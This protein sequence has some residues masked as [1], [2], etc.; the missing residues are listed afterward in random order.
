MPRRARQ[1]LE[2]LADGNASG[3]GYRQLIAEALVQAH[4][5]GD[6]A[7]LHDELAPSSRPSYF[8][9]FVDHARTHGLQY[10]AEADYT[11][12]HTSV[13][14][15]AVALMLAE[16]DGDI[17]AKE[18]YLD[19]LKFRTFRQ[20]LLCRADA[21]LDRSLPPDMAQRFCRGPDAALARR[22]P[23]SCAC[24]PARAS[25]R[26]VSPRSSTASSTSSAASRYSRRERPPLVRRGRR[27]SPPRFRP[28]TA[29][30]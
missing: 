18:Q 4:A 11:E 13:P 28:P 8:H 20:T 5:K 27:G 9:E 1:F 30:P 10:L 23:R 17:V 2:A 6:A 15:P 22:R 25:R 19:F 12:M 26:P 16:Q 24:S 21:T 29:P 7:L 3:P 14:S